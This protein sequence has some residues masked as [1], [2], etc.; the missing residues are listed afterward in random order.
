VPAAYFFNNYAAHEI[1]IHNIPAKAQRLQ[2]K[3]MSED[4]KLYV[5]DVFLVLF[6][7]FV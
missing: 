6:A 5:L 7:F 4:L 1:S 2:R 3:S